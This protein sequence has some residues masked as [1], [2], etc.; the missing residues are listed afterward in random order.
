MAHDEYVTTTETPNDLTTLTPEEI[1]TIL[2][3][4]WAERWK[5]TAYL[6]Q[7]RSLVAP[8]L[9]PGATLDRMWGRATKAL[10]YEIRRY[11][12]EIQKYEARLAEIRAEAGIYQEEFTRRGGWVRYILC[13]NNNG[14]L[15]YDSCHTLKW[16]TR[17]LLVPQASG[18]DASEVV[19]RFGTVAC[20]KCFPGAPV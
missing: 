13:G 16:T 5:I 9:F 7:Y 17:T 11:G 14:H 1:D 8:T 6:N 2:F 20:S 3:P 10:P 18:L 15:H 4:L 12:E 19:G